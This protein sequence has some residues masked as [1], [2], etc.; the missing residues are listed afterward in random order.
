MSHWLYHTDGLILADWPS[1]DTGR[2]FDIFTDRLGLIAAQAI[3]VRE[4]KSKLRY[5]LQTP[6]A[7]QISLVRGRGGWRIVYADTS[8]FSLTR[9]K[10]NLAKLA[11][12]ARCLKLLGRVVPAAGRRPRV[13][14]EISG[15]YQFLARAGL[16]E[17]ELADFEL[18]TIWRILT[19][20]G[21]SQILPTLVPFAAAPWSKKLIIA[22]GLERQAALLIVEQALYHSHL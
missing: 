8:P 4:I 6:A 15:A 13:W 1:G 17:A 21:Y 11:A 20:L 16:T 3:G 10:F 18:L 5:H 7:V 14:R 19:A 9:A 22:F 2:R 12:A